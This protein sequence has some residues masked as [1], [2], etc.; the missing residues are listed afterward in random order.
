MRIADAAVRTPDGK[1][2]TLKRP[3]RHSE[4]LWLVY[5]KTKKAAPPGSDQGFVSE[6]GTF[7]GRAEAVK[8]AVASGQVTHP[9]RT[10]PSW[11]LFTEDLW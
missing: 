2:W 7:L 8:V 9:K 6:C 1:V 4:V 5:D 3:A 10:N 11:E